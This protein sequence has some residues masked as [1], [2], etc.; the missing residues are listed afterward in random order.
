MMVKLKLTNSHS[1]RK[2]MDHSVPKWNDLIQFNLI[3]KN[4]IWF[5]LIDLILFNSI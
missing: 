4:L 1:K 5:D 3:L 2:Y